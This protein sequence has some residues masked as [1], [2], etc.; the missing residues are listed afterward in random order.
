MLQ[1]VYIHSYW[2]YI[3]KKLIA[4][5]SYLRKAL[6]PVNVWQNILSLRT[7]RRRQ[8]REAVERKE[9]LRAHSAATVIQQW[10]RRRQRFHCANR[11]STFMRKMDMA[12]GTIGILESQKAL[13]PPR[14]EF[15][16]LCDTKHGAYGHRITRAKLD[17][18]V[19]ERIE[20]LTVMLGHQEDVT[21]RLTKEDYIEDD[22][23]GEFPG[24]ARRP[25][26]KRVEG[27]LAK[28]GVTQKHALRKFNGYEV[29]VRDGRDL[30][31]IAKLKLGK[32]PI[33]LEFISVAPEWTRQQRIER[34]RAANGD[35]TPAPPQTRYPRYP[36]PPQE[37]YTGPRPPRIERPQPLSPRMRPPALC[38]LPDQLTLPNT[39]SHYTDYSTRIGVE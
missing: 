38:D 26:V 33:I 8:R 1:L 15:L 30:A 21:M 10:W 18:V 31:E 39:D 29:D 14:P 37:N 23:S 4:L 11:H 22:Y 9:I 19:G 16:Y 35:A 3:T 34:I 32:R 17:Y 6:H 7:G 28:R 20:A 13:I 2:G 24:P 5:F 36:E 27:Q 25:M 12:L